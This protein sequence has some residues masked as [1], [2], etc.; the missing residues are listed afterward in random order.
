MDAL[1]GASVR[2]AVI[3]TEARFGPVEILVNNVGGVDRFGTFDD[4]SEAD[5]LDAMDRNLLSALRCALAVLPGMKATG[6]GRIV[7]IGSESALQPGP[8]FPHLAAAK[9]AVL[10]FTKSLAKA[11]ADTGVRVNAV[12]PVCVLRPPIASLLEGIPGAS[13]D[14]SIAHRTGQPDKVARVI[15]MLCSEVASFIDG[16]NVRVDFGATASI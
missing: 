8:Y 16:T 9:A 3:A 4:L 11:N 10:S 2:R 12:S 6:W 5:W 15:A 13:P 7:N 1:D 14:E